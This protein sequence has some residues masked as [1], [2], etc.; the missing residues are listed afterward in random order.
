LAAELEKIHY[1]DE[2]NDKYGYMRMHQALIFKQEIN[3]ISHSVAIPSE[4]TIYRIMD[5]I[6]LIDRRRKPKSL[7]KAEKKAQKSDDLDKPF[8]KVVTDITEIKCKDKKLYCSGMFDCF[9]NYALSIVI[10][11]NMKAELVKNL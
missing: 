9:S 5:Y 6:G 3:E 2:F 8:E 4:R 1:E 10:K 11:T 7:K